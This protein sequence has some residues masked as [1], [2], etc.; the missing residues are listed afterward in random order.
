MSKKYTITL[1]EGDVKILCALARR[2]G[3]TDWLGKNHEDLDW[4]RVIDVGLE[5]AEQLEEQGL[6]A[7]ES[8]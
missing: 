5:V 7:P 8:R 6:E 4:E 3:S 1:N 2:D